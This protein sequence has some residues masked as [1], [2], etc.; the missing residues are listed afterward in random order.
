MSA[1]ILALVASGPAAAGQA[2]QVSGVVELF[3][4]QGCNSCPPADKVLA[5]LADEGNVIALGYHVDYWDY[6]G[7]KDT[8]GSAEYTERQYGYART[9]S[10]RS[11][12]TPQ[13]VVNGRLHLNGGDRR[14]IDGH[15]SRMAAIGEALPVEIAVEENG[16]SLIIRA[17]N[18]DAASLGAAHLVLVYFDKARDVKIDRGENRGKTI[19]YANIVTGIQTAGMWHGE[20]IRYELP[21]SEISKRGDGG[22][23]VILQVV[24][25]KGSPGAILGATLLEH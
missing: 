2:K 15:L 8:L 6:L 10:R 21:M 16:D 14:S 13:A 17:D 20:A 22:C 1:A 11:V 19:T 23:A 25:K 24:G 4:S 5:D 9:F 3:T 7:W 12:Y 18:G